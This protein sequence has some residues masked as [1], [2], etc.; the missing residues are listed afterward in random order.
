M[1]TSLNGNVDVQFYAKVLF[2]REI[3]KGFFTGFLKHH[4]WPLSPLLFN[5][6]LEILIQN[7]YEL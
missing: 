3:M 7:R 1:L 5:T 4:R 6:E 2:N